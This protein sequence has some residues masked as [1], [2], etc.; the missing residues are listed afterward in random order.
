M[1]KF[2]AFLFL[3]ISQS[4]FAQQTEIVYLSGTGADQTKTWDFKC[5]EGR[6]CGEWTTIEVPSQWEQQGFGEYNYGHVPFDKRLKESGHYKYGFGV[7]KSWKDKTVKIVFEGVMTDATVSINGK[8]AGEKHMGAF[9][10]FEFD[11][12]SLLKVGEE[13]TL[14]VIVDKFSANESINW[15]ERQAD[16]WI[17]GGIYRPVFL[18][19]LPKEFIDRV[20]I[21]AEADGNFNTEA[22]LEGLNKAKTVT[23]NIQNLGGETLASYSA[24]VD[25]KADFTEISGM[26]DNPKLWSP[27]FPNLYQMEF[28]LKD[29]RGRV[30]HSVTERTGFRTV[31]VKAQDGIYVNGV[32]VKLK[33]VNRHTFHPDFGRTSSKA[34]SIA[35]VQRIKDMNMNA[36]RMSHYSPDK[37]FLDVADSL[38]L[39]VLDELAG[40]QYPGYDTET[41]RRL[42]RELMYDDMNHPSIVIWDNANEGGWNPEYDHEFKE[43]DIQKREVIHPWAAFGKINAAHYFDY[44]Y[45]SMDNFAQRKIFMPTEFLHGLY[46]GGHGAGLEDYWQKMYHNPL[47]AGGFLWSFAD[48]CINRTDTNELDCDGNHAPDGIFGPYYEKEGSFYTIREIWSP[49]FIAQRYITPDFD[50]SFEIEN[51][52]YY[53]TLGQVDISYEWI[54]I[55]PDGK[56]TKILK[57]GKASVSDLSPMQKGKLHVDLIDGWQKADILSITAHDPHGRLIHTWTYPVKSPD[58]FAEERLPSTSTSAP[59]MTETADAFEFKSGEFYINIAKENASL[60][61]AGN[62]EG[63][64]PIHG[65]PFLVDENVECASVEAAEVEGAYTITARCEE[66]HLN[67]VWTIKADGLVDLDVKYHLPPDVRTFAGISFNYPEEE[68]EGVQLIGDGPYRVWKNRLAGPQFGVW[69][70]TYNNTITGYSGYEYPEFKGFYSNLYKTEFHNKTA[71]D[72]SVFS[73]S[74]DI[75]LRLFTPELQPDPA[76]TRVEFPAGDISF[77]HGIMPIGTKFKPTHELGPESSR[78]NYL[79][80]RIDGSILQMSLTFNFSGK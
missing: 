50:G 69:D 44:N 37:H 41:G 2:I 13:N 5:S 26:F 72:F 39:F 7:P 52:F 32:K 43:L 19:V 57:S 8:S 4:A 74:E 22:H 14:E 79:P 28:Q 80:R 35:D 63:E 17:F 6:N 68:I 60:I 46:D 21:N 40:W 27:E 25:K 20:A 47:N 15:A 34:F 78:F 59:T 56:E 38:G 18:E 77:M 62:G 45:L 49:L 71:P 64:F 61:K 16:Y 58:H 76:N 23:V 75:F 31:E 67:I 3:F 9:N 1:Y 73:K 33:G 70:K 65:G 24:E 11:I 12:S 42:L 55:S 48:E 54:Q 10:R 51:R 30:L 36:V 66:R 53:T 29:K